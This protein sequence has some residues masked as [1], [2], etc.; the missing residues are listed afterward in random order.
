MTYKNSTPTQTSDQGSG[1]SLHDE[2]LDEPSVEENEFRSLISDVQLSKSQHGQNSQKLLNH[3]GTLVLAV[4]RG[5][6]NSGRWSIAVAAFLYSITLLAVKLI[7]N[8]I[9]IFEIL[10]TRSFVSMIISLIVQWRSGTR[11]IYGKREN[12]HLLLCRAVTGASA[13]MS[14]YCSVDLLPLGD[15]TAIFFLNAASTAIFGWLVL[16]QR[17]SLY[18]TIGVFCSIVGVVF[19]SHPPFLFGGHQESGI[20]R[21]KGVIFGLFSCVLAGVAFIMIRLIGKQENTVTVALWFHTTSLFGVIPVIVGYPRKAVWPGPYEIFILGVISL[22]SFFGQIMLTRGFQQD[23]ASRIAAINYLQVV[24]S[25][26]WGALFLHN[27]ITLFGVLGA[28]FI[29]F[30]VVLVNWKDEKDDQEYQVQLQEDSES[31]DKSVD[32]ELV[33][34]GD[35]KSDDPEEG[36]V[37]AEKSGSEV[38]YNYENTRL[39]HIEIILTKL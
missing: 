32:I 10:I 35:Q 13:F 8:K 25:Y 3:I 28:V 5:V 39:H 36:N 1:L 38:R 33:D 2:H 17:L 6:W 22:G 29:A 14:F 15:A 20:E 19:V 4:P 37:N 27:A 34:V 11:P 12:M 31:A 7:S 26:A 21:T 30:G 18:G 23:K 24:F 9:Q 16:K